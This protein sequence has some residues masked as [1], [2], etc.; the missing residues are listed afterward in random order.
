MHH[1]EVAAVL[2]GETAT[3]E[4]VMFHAVGGKN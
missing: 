4:M 2:D 3:E 1:G